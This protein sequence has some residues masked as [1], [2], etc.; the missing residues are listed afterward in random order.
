MDIRQLNSFI[1]VVEFKSF[2]RAAKHLNVAQPALGLQIRRL[3]DELQVQLLVRH[4]RGVE[5]TPAGRVLLE[6]AH[7][8]SRSVAE[9]RQALAR[10][11]G[12]PRG[13]VL[14]GMTPS[15]NYMISADLIRRCN[16][17]LPDVSLSIEEQLS[18]GVVEWVALERLDMCL[19]YK[20]GDPTGLVFEPL[21]QEHL[22]FICSRERV[23]AAQTTIRFADIA[24]HS[25]I[26][27]GHPHGLRRLVEELAVEHGVLLD[28]SF[29]MQSVSVVQDLVADGVGATILP[30]GGARRSVDEGGLAALRIIEPDV[31]RQIY[32]CYHQRRIPTTA[33]EHVRTLIR[34]VVLA[35]VEASTGSWLPPGE[36]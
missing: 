3:E 5:P 13:R 7:Q 8:I 10:F 17:E 9:A 25:L 21:F 18:A 14:L 26:M 19:A 22:Y 30:Y 33:E 24:H 16:R 32:L 4:S 12:P 29:E 1:Q 31:S 15:I 20:I 11:S 2:T 23:P 34:N 27:P 36:D 28:V 6:H 35:I